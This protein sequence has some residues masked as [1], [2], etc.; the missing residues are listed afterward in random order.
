MPVACSFAPGRGEIQTSRHAGGM[1]SASMRSSA[2]AST[3]GSAFRSRYRN[4]PREPR[5]RQPPF[6]ATRS[7]CPG[8][9]STIAP[10]PGRTIVVLDGDETGQELLEQALRVL[11]S[12][13]IGVELDLPRFDLS[14]ANRRA[15][16]NRVVHDAA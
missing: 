16:G 10:V 14:L 2:R 9:G 11:A 5:R 1:R 3:I 12:D 4:R 7:W 6:G 13:V 15:T 8:T